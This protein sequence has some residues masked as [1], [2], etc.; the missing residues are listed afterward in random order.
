MPSLW[1]GTLDNANMSMSP[2]WTMDSKQFLSNFI[3]Y[4]METYKPI[5]KFVWKWKRSKI[6]QKNLDEQNS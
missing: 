5:L 3:W 4:F 2:N 1:I 6:D